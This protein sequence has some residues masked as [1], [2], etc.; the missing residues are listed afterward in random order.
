MRQELGLNSFGER[1]YIDERGDLKVVDDQGRSMLGLNNSRQKPVFVQQRAPTPPRQG[2]AQQVQAELAKNPGLIAS[3]DEQT[4]R[5]TR[6]MLPRP[7]YELTDAERASLE[8]ERKALVQSLPRLRRTERRRAESRILELE[9]SLARDRSG[10]E[11][12]RR[13]GERVDERKREQGIGQ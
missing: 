4:G 6:C 8:A 5:V 7:Y 11:S 10:R 3:V 2:L 1:V 13:D 9:R 12:A